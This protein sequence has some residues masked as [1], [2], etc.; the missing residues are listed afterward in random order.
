MDT[1]NLVV[2]GSSTHRL[3]GKAHGAGHASPVSVGVGSGANLPGTVLR[4]HPSAE[5]CSVN[6]VS[7]LAIRPLFV[8]E[9]FFFPRIRT[10]CGHGAQVIVEGREDSLMVEKETEKPNTTPNK[11][12]NTAQGPQAE[13]PPSCSLSSVQGE[14]CETKE[15][16]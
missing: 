4:Q 10:P 6:E 2:L 5:G 15:C 8:S 12:T 9:S 16:V 1:R 3:G 13:S 14:T 7:H 11:Q